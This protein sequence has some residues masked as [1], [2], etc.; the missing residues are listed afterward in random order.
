MGLTPQKKWVPMSN[1]NNG[2]T[3]I[4]RPDI[5]VIDTRNDY[6]IEIGAFKNAI[7][8]NQNLSRDSTMGG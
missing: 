5:V 6:E 8:S 4:E 2:I 3:L 1:P 7:Q